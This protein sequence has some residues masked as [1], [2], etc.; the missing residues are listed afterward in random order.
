MKENLDAAKSII[1]SVASNVWG[2]LFNALVLFFGWLVAIYLLSP[3]FYKYAPTYIY[4]ITGATLAAQWQ[5]TF[6]AFFFLL[7]I[8]DQDPLVFKRNLS[9]WVIPM[10]T[11]LLTISI[12]GVGTFTAYIYKERFLT[13]VIWLFG[14]SYITLTCCFAYAAFYELVKRFFRKK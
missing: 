5:F 4:L 7:A 8:S 6:L 11:A 1:D 10:M 3:S 9:G 12:L 13:L 2:M 14:P